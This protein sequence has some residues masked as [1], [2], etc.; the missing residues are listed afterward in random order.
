MSFG[1]YKL[2]QL[3]DACSLRLVFVRLTNPKAKSKSKNQN[4]EPRR[5]PISK[6]SLSF[7]RN[8]EASNSDIPVS[9]T[10]RVQEDHVCH[11]FQPCLLGCHLAPISHSLA[12]LRKFCGRSLGDLVPCQTLFVKSLEIYN[13]FLLRLCILLGRGLARI[14]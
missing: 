14:N 9:I 5:F 4:S 7:C 11:R 3:I 13:M 10:Q 6:Q 12:K 2:G 8:L 1:R